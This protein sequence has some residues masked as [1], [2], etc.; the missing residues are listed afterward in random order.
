MLNDQTSSGRTGKISG[1][2]N[3]ELKT[4]LGPILY[5]S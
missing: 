2:P 3:F 1:L 5:I 4:K